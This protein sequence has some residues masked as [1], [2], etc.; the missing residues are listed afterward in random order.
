MK[1]TNMKGNVTTKNYQDWIECLDCQF[2][3]ISNT[4]NQDIGNDMDRVLNHPIFGK[5]L[6]S[7][8]LDT[9]SI[10]FFE[11]AHTRKSITEIDIHYVNNSDPIFTYA[12]IHLKNALVNHYSDT[13][14]LGIHAK[15][16]ELIILAYTSIE[17][18]YIPQNPDNSPGSPIV[19]GFD[20]SQGQVM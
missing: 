6:I 20:L 8:L 12:K 18:T 14:S 13:S 10:S 5:F 15:P 16:R 9:S 4:I 19:S 1:A 3:G 17:K 7:K 2:E 11:H